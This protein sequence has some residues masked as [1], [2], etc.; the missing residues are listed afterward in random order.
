MMLFNPLLLL[1]A[2][3][4][5]L[6]ILAHLLNR[7]QVKH[8][9]WAAMR[10]L[11]RSVRVRSRQLRLRDLV[12]LLMR[13]AAVVLIALAVARPSLQASSGVAAA[14]GSAQPGVII[15]I[16]ASYSML[17]E[18]DG[19]TRFDRA[20]E[21][22][23]A[24][25]DGI[26]IG[27]PVSLV[28]LGDNHRVVARSMSF[29]RTRFDEVLDEQKPSH[30]RLRLD[31]V[32][33]V[34]A[35]LVDET[36][37][38][39]KEVY[40]ITDLQRSDWH[41][42]P[43][44]LT[45][46]LTELADMA[47]SYVVSASGP[48][49]NLAVTDFELFSGLLRVGTTAR[50]S[51]TV[52]NFGDAPATNVAV[53]CLMDENVID[54]KTIR[55]IGP[56]ASQTVS[57]FVPF[58]TAGP[59]SLSARI[60]DDALPLDNARRTVANIRRRVS[61]LSVEGASAGGLGSFVVKALSARGSDAGNE[62]YTV[63]SVSWLSLPAQDLGKFDVVVL[64]NV[65]E[66]TAEQAE[67]L[68]DHARQGGGLIWFGGDRVKADVWNA[69][70]A[71][72]SGALLPARIEA[73]ISVRGARGAGRPLD[74]QLPDH[75]VCRP[76]RSLPKDLLSETTFSE[77]L[78]VTPLPASLTLLRLSGSDTPVLLEQSMGRGHVFMCT[79]AADPSWNNLALTPVFP[80]LLQQMVTY[81]TGREF[82]RPRVVGGS[83]SLS[84][85]DRPDAND[86][87][88][89]TPSQRIIR[90]PVREHGGQFVA[91]LEQAVESG[92]YQARVSLQEP[93]QPIAVNVDTRESDVRCLD[94]AAAERALGQAGV[95]VIAAGDGAPAESR[96]WRDLARTFLIAALALLFIESIFAST[97][98][99]TAFRRT[100]VRR[101]QAGRPTM[102]E[103]S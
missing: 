72:A 17:H 22:I 18:A 69:R 66:I 62:D 89:E 51:A 26:P 6:P 94:V 11:N 29:D 21:H 81:L 95:T 36:V 58:Q 19:V 44:W 76:L 38:A 79:S 84:Y 67:R 3:G 1:A 9:D 25:A 91:F 53:R 15:A 55:T 73:P 4:I 2:A 97:A 24:I 56:R 41:D 14:A 78:S 43:A 88:F 80:M 52:H 74:P 50:Y 98:F 85:A 35:N 75:E 64:S 93:G 90:V 83:L 82:E 86:G 103:A 13:C 37:A 8:T 63:R 33:P 65:P 5:A 45:G 71:L 12:L 32:A 102:A 27:S 92:I 28:V 48:A 70:A 10:F 7:F 54:T 42:P 99:S 30:G 20:I 60:D 49:A 101:A 68:A 46:A 47:D 39:E 87:M 40:L 57:F 96:S 59:V 61:I 77:L 31:T 34:I 16:D 100:Q 23:R